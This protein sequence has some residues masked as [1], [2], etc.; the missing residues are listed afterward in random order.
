M[1]EANAGASSRPTQ[2][3]PYRILE[4]LGRGGMGTVYKAERREPVRQLV[5]LK[6]VQ[7][8]MATQDVLARFALERRALAAMNHRCIAKVFDAGATDKGE[9]YFVMELVEGLPFT[10]YCDKHRLSL[11]ERLRLFQKV[12]QGVQHAHQKG[13]VHRD[14]K[15]G[16]VL[17]A[18]EGEEAIPKILDFGLAKATNRDFLDATLFTAMD[19]ILG[20]PEYMSPEQA[21]GDG[22]VID[23]RADV[24]SLGVMLYELLSG[25]LP[26]TTQRLKKAGALEAM[27]IIREVEPPKPSTKLVST[28]DLASVLCA[29]RRTSI[30]TLSRAL[31]G[32]LDW[33][34]MC[35][36]AKEPER[37]YETPTGLA[38]DIE[39][40]LEHEPVLAG[41]PSAAYRLKKLLR[42]YRL[43]VLAGAAVLV[44]ALTGAGIATNFAYKADAN[45]R[46][47]NDR[48]D[49]IGRRKTEFDQLA[50]VVLYERAVEEEEKLYP[51]WPE[52]IGSLEMWL[53]NDCGKLLA[54]QPEI[55]KTVR[56][57]RSRALPWTAAEQQADRISHP[58]FAEWEL[59]TERVAALRRAQ[60]VRAGGQLVIPALPAGMRSPSARVLDDLAWERV[61]PRAADRAI[62]GE[63]P[64][65]LAYARA[66]IANFEA[67][68]ST[69]TRCRLL[70]TLAWALAANG[71]DEEA[72]QR[73]AE[74]LTAAPAVEHDAYATTHRN[75][76][77]AVNSATAV[78]S[79]LE[80]ESRT[81]TIEVNTRSSFQL[82]DESQRFLHNTLTGL[83]GKLDRLATKQKVNVERRLF[84]ARGIDGLTRNH[85]SARVTWAAAS[86]AI[87]KAD[88]IVANE[89][90]RRHPIRDL[91]PQTG[92]VPIGMNPVTRLWEFYE[93]RSAW[94]GVSDRSSLAIPTH[95]AEGHIAVGD[96][97]GIVFVLIPGD[98]FTMG[99]QRD[100][101][102]PNHDPQAE[103]NE[104]PHQ[105]TLSP[106]FLARHELTQGQWSRLATGE[107]ELAPSK[108]HAGTGFYGGVATLSHP[109]EQVDWDMCM[110]LLTRHGLLL[111]TEAQWEYACR[112]GTTTPWWTGKELDS[113]RGAVNLADLTARDSGAT[114]A[115][116]LDWPELR[117]GFALLAP[118][119]ALIPNPWGLVHMHGNVLE[120]T[121]DCIGSYW[122]PGRAGDG[123]RQ[124]EPVASK[125]RV[126]RGGCYYSSPRF[127]R[128]SNR[129]GYAPGYRN[130]TIG[131][132]AAR[133]LR[134]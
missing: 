107:L 123:L 1:T 78:L 130:F 124:V 95:D 47:A 133:A 112:A 89:L 128:S 14:L 36:M 74:A 80:T 13:V 70:S 5:A 12:C 114:W 56:N 44:T 10:E 110:T 41:P 18:R 61:A 15:P 105:V 20:T 55:E 96:D 88:D 116:Q 9:P 4:E 93:L 30:G 6:V 119:D 100:S 134:E 43:Q 131:L 8:G 102:A 92:L 73:S 35:A 60:T 71:L 129:I 91:K 31:R 45:A 22:E 67:G 33:V 34:V 38:M 2:I 51:A 53:R 72:K 23:S 62:Y 82:S 127:S 24:Y 79:A 66:A 121:R 68:D 81:L 27:R 57:L 125:D 120:W 19:R 46:T 85:P 87:A 101:T 49:E 104:T 115:S 42:R 40:Y 17:V 132:R 58:R 108:Y 117:D 86:A 39:R 109:V 25:E 126:I 7:A 122:S 63:E 21:A 99:A 59:S 103:D 37:R 28:Q 54:M 97:T 32:D 50:G 83:L 76:A 52:N 11:P 3:G 64:L 94:D 65:G 113:L 90:Y 29:Q 16:N 111:P 75:L 98:T 69:I 118:V 106:Y 77:A 26:F 84:W 48:A